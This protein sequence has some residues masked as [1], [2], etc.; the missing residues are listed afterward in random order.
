ME[1]EKRTA[2]RNVGED[3]EDDEKK[4]EEFFALIRNFKDVRNQLKDQ[5]E[6]GNNKRKRKS[7]SDSDHHRKSVAAWVP[8]F[9]WED[10]TTEVEFRRPSYVLPSPCN[11]R[12][13]IIKKDD[14][15]TG[16]SGLDL[17]L[18]L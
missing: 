5:T 13:E 12:N 2:E 3:E 6:K 4:M 18:A 16:S 7:D 10:F 15:V 8:A 17:K 1:N 9:Q 14:D 11:N